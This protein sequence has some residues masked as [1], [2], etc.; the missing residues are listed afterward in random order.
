MKVS[1][2]TGSRLHMGFTNLSEDVGRSYG[3]IGVT[4]DR[5]RTTVV[6]ERSNT[7]DIA[8]ENSE[9][10]WA[11]VRRFS[12]YFSVQPDV[13]VDVR[14]RIPEHA[15][16]GSGTQLA[17]ALGM[18]LATMSGVRADVH[19]VARAMG[20]GR[21]SGV[22]VAAFDV[23][24]SIIDAG[25][26]KNGAASGSIPTIVFRRNFPS[27]WRFVVAIPGSRGGLSGPG[28]E[29]AFRLLSAS[30]RVSEEICR[31]T[32]LRLMPALVEEDIQE[33]GD[34][35]TAIDRKTGAYF[36]DVQG[37]VYGG[38]DTG[39]LIETML[40]AGAYGAGQSSWGPAVYGLVDQ[41]G[42][43]RVEEEAR[44]L[45]DK[46]QRGGSVFVARGRNVGARINVR[47]ENL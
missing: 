41:D 21:R 23:G 3:S 35:L 33:F 30:T 19:E 9:R 20:R 12:E 26:K 17:L 16:L 34:A 43:T 28:E 44:A 2:E 39:E 42:A 36:A 4:L 14:D 25:H 40:E 11:Y 24:G 37:G 46:T 32:Q 38:G 15:G 31:L 45:L 27:E 8:G 7:L 10:I 29:K 1:V 22:G 47:M 5:P 13:T 6:L 18:A